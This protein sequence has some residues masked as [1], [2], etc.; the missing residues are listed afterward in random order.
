MFTFLPFISPI[1]SG[2]TKIEVSNIVLGSNGAFSKTYDTLPRCIFVTAQSDS[3][4]FGGGISISNGSVYAYNTKV[5]TPDNVNPWTPSI[6]GTT[7]SLDGVSSRLTN[8]HATL[9][10]IY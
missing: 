1:N 8:A 9:V 4:W 10:E 2:L 7:L 6:S 3:A 5:I